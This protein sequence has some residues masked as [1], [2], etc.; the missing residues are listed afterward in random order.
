MIQV[1]NISKSFAKRQVL[2]DVSF[3]LQAGEVLGIVGPNGSGK[4][5]LL[6]VL[7]GNLRPNSGAINIDGLKMSA[8]LSRK[9]FIPDMSVDRNFEFFGALTNASNEAIEI[10]KQRFNI[11]YGV[12]QY[13]SLSAGMQQRVALA[14]AFLNN[15]DVVLL[16]E[17]SNHLDVDSAIILRNTIYHMKSLRVAFILTSHALADLQRLCTRIAF[18]NGGTMTEF[19]TVQLMDDFGS[20]ESAYLKLMNNNDTLEK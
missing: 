6:N 19:S 7:V 18:L 15:P 11:D 13:R 4:T 9:G 20:V 1:R 14:L 16:D 5:T 8:C 17:P 12:K 10:A 3:H 2:R